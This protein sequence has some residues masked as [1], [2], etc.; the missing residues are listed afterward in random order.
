VFHKDALGRFLAMSNSL[1]LTASAIEATR[2]LV[3]DEPEYFGKHL[4]VYLAGKGCDGFDYGVTFD[5]E[6][7]T[8]VVYQIESDIRLIC[9][10][11]SMEFVAGSSIDWVDD[12]RGRG[13]LVNNPNH[14]KFRG[15][16]YKKEV[17][18][19]KLSES[20]SETQ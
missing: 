8:D 18:R 14:R 9:D 16:F 20:A 7:P 11:R 19:K 6:D 17:W 2:K 12:E 1:T 15:K 10:Q 4:R 13:F 5:H 3:A